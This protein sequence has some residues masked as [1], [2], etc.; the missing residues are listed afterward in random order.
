MVHPEQ[1]R[2]DRTRIEHVAVLWSWHP[3][4]VA[5]HLIYTTHMGMEKSSWTLT[6]SCVA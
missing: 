6:G 5:I 4:K 3:R 2:P 1:I